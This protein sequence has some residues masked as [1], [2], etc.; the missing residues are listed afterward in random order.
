MLTLLSYKTVIIYPPTPPSTVIASG[1]TPSAT[2]P[3]QVTDYDVARE[4]DNFFTNL[5]STFDVFAQV[6]NLTYL[7]PPI[8]DDLVTFHNMSAVMACSLSGETLT[9]YLN[10][11]QTKQWFKD[12]KGFRR[13]TTHRHEI[14]CDI[15]SRR[16]LMK[17]SADT[18]IILPDNPFSYPPMY[19]QNREFGDF[20]VNIFN[21]TSKALDD[22]YGIADTKIE[23]ADHVPI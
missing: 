6:I 5:S 17:T 8:S 20:G 23:A 2:G 12:L 14:E 3:P 13:C 15:K 4:I 10:S 21:E 18:E 19:S 7:T 9:S 22:I 1:G 16:G 11:L